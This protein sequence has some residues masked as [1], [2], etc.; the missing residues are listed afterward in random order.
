MFNIRT[1]NTPGTHTKHKHTKT[2]SFRGPF[3]HRH[4]FHL[5]ALGKAYMYIC[6]R[7]LGL[8]GGFFLL[9][10]IFFIFPV[11]IQLIQDLLL[12]EILILC[13]LLSLPLVFD[14]LSQ[15][16]GIR[17]SN[18]LLRVTVGL[19]TTLAGMIMLIAYQFIW[20]TLPVGISWFLLVSYAG[21]YWKNHR[22]PTFGCFA[23]K[24]QFREAEITVG[25]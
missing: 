16:K 25:L 5:P 14:W 17:H 12:V 10:L 15:S 21:R 11:L 2:Q 22:S 7:C 3:E 20:I 8:Y 19:L 23:C 6:A 4:N 18:N 9:A 1:N 13:F 24:K